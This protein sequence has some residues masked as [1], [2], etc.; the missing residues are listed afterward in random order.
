MPKIADLNTSSLTFEW[1]E[2]TRYQMTAVVLLSQELNLQLPQSTAPF[3]ISNYNGKRS[4]SL[5]LD[6]ETEA[7]LDK[8]DGVVRKSLVEH[9]EWLGKTKVTE[10]QLDLLYTKIVRPSPKATYPP[11][12]KLPLKLVDVRPDGFVYETQGIPE[13]ALSAGSHAHCSARTIISLRGIWIA[14]GRCGPLLAL[15]RVLFQ[16][17]LSSITDQIKV[18]EFE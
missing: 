17:G 14:S 15:R 13:S 7:Q 6:P 9:P 8:L 12:I 3:R 10:D 16:E 4:L 2:L 5:S 11:T 1:G 18:L